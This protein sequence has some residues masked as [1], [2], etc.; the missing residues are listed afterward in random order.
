MIPGI[1]SFSAAAALSQYPLSLQKEQLLISPV[2]DSEED[3]IKILDDSITN[4]RVLVFL[5]LGSRW[6]WVRR[7]LE[8]RK[9]LHKTLFA[10]KVGL[11][12]QEISIAENVPA[13]YMPYLSLLIIRNQLPPIMP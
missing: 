8:E 5:K 2:P 4:Q 3:F 11:S 12:D 10:Q 6:L 9:L 7:I 1:N 13:S